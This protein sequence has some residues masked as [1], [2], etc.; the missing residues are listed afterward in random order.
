ASLAARSIAGRSRSS[1]GRRVMTPSESGGSGGT[2]LTLSKRYSA[3][4]SSEGRPQARLT[5][6]E[7]RASIVRSAWSATRS[8]PQT[9][10]GE[11][12]SSCFLGRALGGR[13]RAS[14]ERPT[15]PPQP[16]PEAAPR[17]QAT[18]E[19]VATARL[20]ALRVARAQRLAR[21]EEP[22]HP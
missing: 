7:S 11:R 3:A 22:H 13:Q 18:D 17:E 19:Q 2:R 9:R 1:R 6:C 4:L 10:S 16:P 15:L 20:D 21:P 5:A 12:P 14:L 8:S